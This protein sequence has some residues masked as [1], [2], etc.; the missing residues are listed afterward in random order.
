MSGSS[1]ATDSEVNK[2]DSGLRNKALKEAPN[3][4]VWSKLD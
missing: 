4:A 2:T 1:L 3:G